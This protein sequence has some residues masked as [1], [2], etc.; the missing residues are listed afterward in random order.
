MRQNKVL[1]VYWPTE[2][3][4]E[5][6]IKKF[7]D[8]VF[9]ARRLNLGIS[10]ETGMYETSVLTIE[11]SMEDVGQNKVSVHWIPKNLTLEL[12]WQEIN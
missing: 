11:L 9:K 4:T 5:E 10:N 1:E 12:R 3:G 7:E 2:I 6:N 8:I